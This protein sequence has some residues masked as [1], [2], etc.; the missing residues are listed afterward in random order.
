MY[1]VTE[2]VDCFPTDAEIRI[3]NPD[4]LLHTNSAFILSP[5]LSGD[6]DIWLRDAEYDVFVVAIRKV[7]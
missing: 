7:Y 2:D 4:Y 1:K 6:A 5:L 3:K